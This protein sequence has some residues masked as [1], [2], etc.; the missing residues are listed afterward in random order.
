M[1]NVPLSCLIIDD[2]APSRELPPLD[3]NTPHSE[4]HHLVEN[5]RVVRV[6]HDHSLLKENDAKLCHSLE[7]ATRST[8]CAALIKSCQRKNN[9]MAL[10]RL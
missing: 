7:E 9:C 8:Q 6:S 4:E 1:R 5:D 10:I 2:T 3:P